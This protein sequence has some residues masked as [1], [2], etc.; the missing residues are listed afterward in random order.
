MHPSP[1]FSLLFFVCSVAEGLDLAGIHANME[2][3]LITRP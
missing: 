2:V 1:P 3:D